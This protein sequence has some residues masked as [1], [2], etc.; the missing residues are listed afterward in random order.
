ML[1][2][3]TWKG[4]QPVA[5]TSR[6]NCPSKCIYSFILV[7]G[8]TLVSRG[9]LPPDLLRETLLSY[10]ILFPSVGDARSRK[11]LDR[12]TAKHDLDSAFLSSLQYATA[13]RDAAD[14]SR[15]PR[16]VKELY[17]RFPFWGQRLHELWDEAENPTPLTYF[18][19]LSERK[20]SPRFT[21]WCAAIGI[22]LAI[23]FGVLATVLGGIQVWISYCSW[24]DDPTVRGCSAGAKRSPASSA[25]P[26]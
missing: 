24:L 26:E 16:D 6:G 14:Q 8:L 9:C 4:Q 20:K 10:E 7:M 3:A 21:Y 11:I 12:E 22:S 17:Q 19:R 1:W 2:L 5:W 23:M 13:K 15:R 18:D 25:A